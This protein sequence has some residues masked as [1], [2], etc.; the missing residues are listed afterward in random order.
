MSDEP[1]PDHPPDE[2]RAAEEVARRALTLFAV[3]GLA[4]RAERSAVLD[5]LTENDLWKELSPRERGFVDT[6]NPSRRQII[7]ASW[8]SECL[9]VMLWA[10]GRLSALS[11]ADEQ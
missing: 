7:D 10:L 11:P 9:I 3:V 6:P 2:I 4:L 8:Q 5:W 1:E